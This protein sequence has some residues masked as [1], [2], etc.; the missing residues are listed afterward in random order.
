[1][2]QPIPA[3]PSNR[4][5]KAVN[6]KSPNNAAKIKS[7]ADGT[8]HRAHAGAESSADLFSADPSSV[9]LFS[10]EDMEPIAIALNLIE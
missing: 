6:A 5:D 3:S 10:V 7:P 9:D 1:M 2:C 8:T 4:T